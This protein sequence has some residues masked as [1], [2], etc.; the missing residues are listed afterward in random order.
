MSFP[1]PFCGDPWDRLLSCLVRL[2]SHQLEELKLQLQA[3]EL[4]PAAPR[5]F[6][7]ADLRALEPAPLLGLLQAHF[8]EADAWGLVLGALE[9]MGLAELG[10]DARAARAGECSARG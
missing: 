4:L 7:W 6:S 10:A 3:P 9:R 8:L 5:P 2:D 1:G